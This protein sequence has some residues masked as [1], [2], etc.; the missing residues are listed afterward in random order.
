MRMLLLA[1]GDAMK[2]KREGKKDD[3]SEDEQERGRVQSERKV[4]AGRK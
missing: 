3:E 4:K 2:E 1:E